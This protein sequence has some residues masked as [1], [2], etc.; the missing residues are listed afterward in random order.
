MLQKLKLMEEDWRPPFITS[1][2]MSMGLFKC[3]LQESDVHLLRRSTDKQHLVCQSCCNYYTNERG[4]SLRILS[5]HQRDRRLKGGLKRRS[6]GGILLTA[7]SIYQLTRIKLPW[8]GVS[9]V[10]VLHNYQHTE[11]DYSWPPNE[12]KALRSPSWTISAGSASPLESK[13]KSRRVTVLSLLRW[14]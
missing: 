4:A 13:Y 2:F 6:W 10:G 8:I 7:D 9:L 14:D 1:R 11:N 5:P 3:I 12:P